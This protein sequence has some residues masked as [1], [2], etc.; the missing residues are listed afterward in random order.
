MRAKTLGGVVFALV[1]A[2]GCA[3]PVTAPADDS[4]F[5]ASIEGAVVSEYSG[6]GHFYQFT[7]SLAPWPMPWLLISTSGNER[8]E[9]L[10]RSG[11]LPEV[12]VYEL[13]APV[14]IDD[15]PPFLAS[16]SRLEGG[17]E[18]RYMAVSGVVEITESS[19][20]RVAGT[21]R[22]SAERR[23]VCRNVGPNARSC[24]GTQEDDPPVI[25]VS[26]SFEAVPFQGRGRI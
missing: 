16:Y 13:R 2:A 14:D 20:E 24:E 15:P 22:F 10:R 19:P 1:A 8:F 25:E 5:N 17:Q 12:G 3:E 21:F 4:W 26:G 6:A 23:T 11:G 18:D 9:L 7:R